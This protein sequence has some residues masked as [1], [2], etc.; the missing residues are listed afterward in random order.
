M[1]MLN[2]LVDLVV[3]H[4]TLNNHVVPVTL[5][6]CLFGFV[7]LKL[8]LRVTVAATN[9]MHPLGWNLTTFNDSH[10]NDL[11]IVWGHSQPH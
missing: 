5:V 9:L 3:T 7:L 11:R 8:N 2:R 4:R 1:L 6:I 10:A